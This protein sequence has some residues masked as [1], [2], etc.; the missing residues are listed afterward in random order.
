MATSSPSPYVIDVT[1]QDFESAVIERSM[2]VPVLLDCWAPWCG[3]C[4]SLTPI[5]EKVVDSYGGQLVLAKLNSDDNP[6][7]AQA[8]R[9]RSIPAVFLLKEGRVVDQFQGA[10]PEGKVREFL[11][12]HLK[13]EA[14]PIEELRAQA[15]TAD[16]ETAEAMLREG[17]A[18][19]PGHVELTLDLA[20]RVLARGAIDDAQA[21]LD[22][23]PEAGRTDR[24]AALLKRITLLRNRPPGDAKALAARIA[25]NARD[26]EA[27]FADR[28]SVV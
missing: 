23:V 12:R 13:P 14:D 1:D 18:Y 8:L 22:D 3:P 19:D 10:L 20:D 24:H 11:E 7:I 15:A 17:L 9:L 26:H 5:L 16:P 28:K 25:A 27:R 4:R 6:G 21:L 2:Q